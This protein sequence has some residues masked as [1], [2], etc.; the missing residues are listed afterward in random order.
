V[1]LERDQKHAFSPMKM[2]DL[3]GKQNPWR[4][5][6]DHKLHKLLIEVSIVLIEQLPPYLLPLL[7]D[8]KQLRQQM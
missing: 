1:S 8:P 5:R 7:E 2:S 6:L 4:V 3:Q